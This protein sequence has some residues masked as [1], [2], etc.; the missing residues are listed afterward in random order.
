MPALS[1]K[2]NYSFDGMANIVEA[3]LRNRDQ[4][5][6]W[7]LFVQEMSTSKIIEREQNIE[8]AGYAARWPE[9]ANRPE[10]DFSEGYSTAFTQHQWAGR[11]GITKVIEKFDQKGLKNRLVNQL[12]D[13]P[14]LTMEF[15]M[16]CYLDYGD[17]TAPVIGGIPLVNTYG[18][19]GL[20]IFSTAHTWR[21]NPNVTWANKSASADSLTEDALQT[22]YSV[23]RRNRDNAGIPLNYNFTGLIIPPELVQ[24]ATRVMESRLQP[25][26][27]NNA[28]NTA[29]KFITSTGYLEHPWLSSTTAWYLKTDARDG[30]LRCYWGWKPEKT[31][32]AP[33]PGTGNVY[34]SVDWSFASGPSAGGVFDLY[35]VA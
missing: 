3:G 35:K 4:K 16:A 29:S 8:N 7:A 14:T 32:S 9:G 15:I 5:K 19:D 30:G 21:S 6:R 27:A 10:L 12:L 28:V 25:D 33:E 24:A 18:G 34:I 31:I 20:T 2:Y 13:S 17:S 22:A 23:I 26:T 1:G 11:I